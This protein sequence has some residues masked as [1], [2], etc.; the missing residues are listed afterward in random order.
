MPL[1]ALDGKVELICV[2]IVFI[3]IEKKLE[4]DTLFVGTGA[5]RAEINCSDQ[6]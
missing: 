2:L 1:P 6:N 3:L 4:I 5:S